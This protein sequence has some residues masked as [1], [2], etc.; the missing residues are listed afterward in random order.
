MTTSADAPVLVGLDASEPARDAVRW[1][2]REALARNAP[3]HLV[4]AFGWMPVHD[5]DDPFQLPPHQRDALRA[6]AERALAAAAREAARVA[7]GVEVTTELHTG[8][9]AGLLVEASRTARVLVV[10]HRGAGGFATLLLG[11]VSGAVAAHAACPVV[12][13]RGPGDGAAP[14]DAGPVVVGVDGSPASE[15]ALAFAVDAAVRRGAPLVAVHAWDE[16]GFDMTIATQVD[17][18]GELAKQQALVAERLA[19]WHDK[20]PDL[21][22]ERVVVHDHPARVLRDRSAGAALLV[23][24]S[25]G[26][27]GFA[28]LLLGSVSQDLLRHAQCPVAVVRDSA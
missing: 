26:R 11:S 21:P 18:A 28:G 19:P 27:G 3:L 6:D 25:R 24:G 22:I 13:V 2:A 5:E 1:G 16:I 10:G 8:T 7:P 4:T 20:H 15:T 14:P 17:P 23:V 12:V 9:P